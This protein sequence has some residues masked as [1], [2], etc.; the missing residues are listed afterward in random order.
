MLLDLAHVAKYPSSL[1]IP[2]SILPLIS[3]ISLTPMAMMR[4]L[5]S[6]LEG[7]LEKLLASTY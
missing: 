5:L 3:A 1:P 4:R 6:D 7:P 2:E